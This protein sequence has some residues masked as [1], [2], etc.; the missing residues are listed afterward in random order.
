[1]V[2]VRFSRRLGQSCVRQRANHYSRELNGVIIQ[3]VLSDILEYST[4]YFHICN[5]YVFKV[6]WGGASLG[7]GG[8]VLGQPLNVYKI[9]MII[10]TILPRCD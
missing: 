3:R 10:K 9:W 6:L 7:C 1:M 8:G 2:F 4:D 5:N